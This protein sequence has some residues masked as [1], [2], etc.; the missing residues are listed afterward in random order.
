MTVFSGA[1]VL[2]MALLSE[3]CNSRR[4]Q[5]QLRTYPWWER[6]GWNQNPAVGNVLNNC[7][8]MAV[9]RGTPEGIQSCLLTEK[10]LLVPGIPASHNKPPAPNPG[11]PRFHLCHDWVT[12]QR[13][14]SI[15]TYKNVFLR[16]FVLN[17]GE[18]R[19]CFKYP[20]SNALFG[21][22]YWL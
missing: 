9:G 6:Q 3:V 20:R 15:K 12:A 18:L 8:G 1:R 2:E 10:R 7:H 22:K 14:G 13:F 21:S 4:K 16:N 19:I 11:Q 17:Q 5:L